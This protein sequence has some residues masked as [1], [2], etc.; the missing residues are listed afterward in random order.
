M[1]LD[2]ENKPLA[3]YFTF[4]DKSDIYLEDLNHL[5]CMGEIPNL[6]SAEENTDI[7]EKMG[8]IDKQRDKTVQVLS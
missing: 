1:Q 3:D 4:K 8:E 6:I 2:Q 5:L 7:I